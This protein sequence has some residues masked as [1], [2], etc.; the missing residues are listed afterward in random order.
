[1]F[2]PWVLPGPA[3]TFSRI[4][5]TSQ[6]PRRWWVPILD[7]TERL[8]VLRVGLAEGGDIDDKAVT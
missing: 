2:L 4:S 6:S 3:V 1:M 7:G 5:G 8:G